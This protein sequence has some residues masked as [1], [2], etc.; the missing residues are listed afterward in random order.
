[1]QLS[2]T[3]IEY[4]YLIKELIEDFRHQNMFSKTVQS[5][6]V[7]PY[8]L[9]LL[10]R[11]IAAAHVKFMPASV[12]FMSVLA[13]ELETNV[14][15]KIIRK[16]ASVFEP[17]RKVSE[18]HHIKE[19]RHIH[20]TKLW[21]KYYTQKAGY[22]KRSWYSVVVLLNIVFIRILYVRKEIFR[23]L[24]VSDPGLYTR[25]ARE[26]LKLNFRKHCLSDIIKF[27]EEFNEFNTITRPLWRLLVKA[28][29]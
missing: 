23:D 1:M 3:S 26:N 29:L 24:G 14:Y 15:G 11:K 6:K 9:G 16:D 4:R 8:Q 28:E 19:G 10:H 7:E 25:V 5:R 2:Q 12:L 22:I 21:L 18:L 13:I 20:Y 17:L 27:V